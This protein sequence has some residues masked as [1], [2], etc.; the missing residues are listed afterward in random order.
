MPTSQSRASYPDCEAFFNAALADDVGARLPFRT[1]GAAMQ[2]QTRLN[3]FRVLC[4]KDNAKIYP[5]RN[6]QLHNRS[7]YDPLQIAVVGPDANG[8]YWVYAKRRDF[9]IVD[10]IEPLSALPNAGW[11]EG[12]WSEPKLLEDKTETS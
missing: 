12:D 5:D 10:A 9:G 2:M 11:V 6:H 3:S 1:H 4:R 7:E 8:E